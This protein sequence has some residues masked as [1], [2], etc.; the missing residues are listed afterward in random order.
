MSTSP[1]NGNNRIVTWIAGAILVPIVLAVF[2]SMLSTT[3]SSSQR[4][5]RLEAEFQEIRDNVLRVERKIDWLVE[6][7][8]P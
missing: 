5:S 6:H 1:T 3:N 7:Q 2:T 8:K 4:I